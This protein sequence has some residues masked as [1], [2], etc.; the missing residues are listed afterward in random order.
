MSIVL[1]VDG[2]NSKTHAIILN[3]CGQVL[4]FGRAGCGNHQRFGLQLALEEI[5]KSIDVALLNANL[6]LNQI[7][8]ASYCL[9]GADLEEDFALLRPALAKLGFSTKY[10]LYNDTFAA[11][12]AGLDKNWG[13]VVVCGAGFN[14]AIK[15]EGGSEFAM[16]G[17]GEISGD[18][19][20]GRA[21]GMEMIR[22]MMRAWD[23]R[24]EPTLLTR[25]LLQY[26]EVE[27]EQ[28]LMIKL[29]RRQISQ[30]KIINSVPM[31]FQAAEAGD[32]VANDLIEELAVEV[33]VTALALIRRF[34]MEEKEV[35]VVLGGSVFKGEGNSLIET[36]RKMVN[37]EAPLA[38]VKRTRFEPVAGA[39]LL[40]LEQ[41][42]V[43]INQ[44]ILRRLEDTFCIESIIP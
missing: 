19:A 17:L 16:P 4:S 10:S 26:Y 24:G 28:T 34:N 33:G 11:L 27:D 36:V 6:T 40:A 25:L 2:G 30:E 22:L 3:E 20:G 13:V 9:A 39:A 31:L 43:C 41:I 44:A 32:Q 12:R 21:L 38:Q 8:F 23:G 14:A 35:E 37:A 29:Y 15:T 1:G 42:G 7:D 5:K 18:W